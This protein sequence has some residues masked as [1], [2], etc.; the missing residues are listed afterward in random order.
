MPRSGSVGIIILSLRVNT[1]QVY[2]LKICLSQKTVE[3]IKFFDQPKNW[4]VGLPPSPMGL[5]CPKHSHIWLFPENFIC[6][7]SGNFIS[8]FSWELYNSTFLTE[9]F[10]SLFCWPAVDKWLG[11][12]WWTIVSDGAWDGRRVKKRHCAR[13]LDISPLENA[14]WWKNNCVLG[15][16]A[17]LPPFIRLH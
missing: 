4:N 13:P 9:N 10:I 3:K 7:F 1:M 11:G 2:N 16:E 8:L 5:W 6:L 17:A 15:K 12:L 14:P